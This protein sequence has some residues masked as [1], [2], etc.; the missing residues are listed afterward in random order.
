L[1]P[2]GQI[3]AKKP[4]LAVVILKHAYR[5]SRMCCARVA[6]GAKGYLL[7]ESAET[8][9]IAAIRAVAQGNVVL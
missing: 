1:R 7:K 4:A 5:M 8:D 6:R 2:P 9:V 3:L